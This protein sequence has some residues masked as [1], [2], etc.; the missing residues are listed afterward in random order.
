MFL[1]EKVREGVLMFRHS[2]DDG[3]EPYNALA[4]TLKHE[5]LKLEITELKTELEQLK[6][7]GGA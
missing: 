5:L 4:L 6:T 3:F 2:P 1:E 7:N